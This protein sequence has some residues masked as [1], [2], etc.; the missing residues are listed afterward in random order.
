[1][2]QIIVGLSLII[3]VAMP[4]YAQQNKVVVVPLAEGAAGSDKQI[5]FNNNGNANGAANF[6]YDSLNSRV[7]FGTDL[8]A[9]DFE[10]MQSTGTASG[11]GGLG[12]KVNLFGSLWKAYHSGSHLSFAEVPNGGSGVRRAYIETGTGNYVQPSSRKLKSNISLINGSLDKVLQLQPV[13][14]NYNDTSPNQRTFGFV[15]EEVVQLFPELVR[16]DEEGEPGIAYAGFGPLAIGAI[17]QQQLQLDQLK[18][19]NQA[20]KARLDRL[21]ELLK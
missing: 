20:L 13:S 21:E 7:G 6:F 9:V 19:E 1:V 18:E 10:I 3:I 4:T 17:K 8:P 14:Y 5:Q 2:K 16:Y 15:A 12:F 11:S